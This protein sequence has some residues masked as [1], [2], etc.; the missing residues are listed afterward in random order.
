MATGSPCSR[1]RVSTGSN[2][3]LPGDAGEESE[4]LSTAEFEVLLDPDSTASADDLAAQ[5]ELL[6]VIR[7]AIER[8]ASILNGAEDLRA[9]L[10]ALQERLEDDDAHGAAA[11]QATALDDELRQIEGAFFDL[12]LTG[13]GQDSLRWER[14]LYARLT[15]LARSVGQA[16]ARPTDQQVAVWRRLQSQLAEQEDRF[17]ATLAG[18]LADLNQAL[19][20]GGFLVLDPR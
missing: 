9:Q 7:D 5:N 16:D 4:A 17:E 18:P 11:E 20:D 6:F 8:A 19:A 1:R 15:Y 2:S 10:P 14:R 13:T 12:R 3:P